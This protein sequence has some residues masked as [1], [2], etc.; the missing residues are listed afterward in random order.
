MQRQFKDAVRKADTT[1]HAT[2]HCMRHCWA[3]HSLQSG[4][5]IR[6]VQD[7]MGTPASR[8]P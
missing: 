3:T 5:D 2:S 1:K 6:T 4:T 8:P 7:L